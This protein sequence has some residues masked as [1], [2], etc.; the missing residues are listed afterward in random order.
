MN[1]DCGFR[2]MGCKDLVSYD[3]SFHDLFNVTY[4]SPYIILF[5]G[6]GYWSPEVFLLADNPKFCNTF[7]DCVRNV[8]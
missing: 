4:F 5:G 7:W 8:T 1:H 3:V 2:V 6:F